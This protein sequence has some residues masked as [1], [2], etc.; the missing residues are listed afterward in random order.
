MNI[1]SD[2]AAPKPHQPR[3]PWKVPIALGA[4]IA[5][6][7]AAYR[8]VYSVPLL[9]DDNEAILNNL[10]I[11][12]LGSAFWPPSRAAVFGRPVLNLSL[13]M[14]YAISGTA[15]WSYHAVNLAIHILAGLTLFGIVRR[16]IVN[17][18]GSS[19]LPIAFSVA[20]IWTLHP[21]QTEAVTYIV[22][23]AESLMALFYLLTLYC[24]IRGAR[25]EGRQQFL[26]FS[27]SAGSCLLG[28]GTKEVM[29][30]APLIVL[31]YDRTFLSGSFREALRRHW[32]PFA[33][34]AA[35]WLALAYL[36]L[37]AY[38]RGVAHDS[39][40]AI[41]W[42]RYALTQLQAVPHYLWL[43]IWPHPLIF[44]YGTSLA[45]V[46]LRILPF[47]LIVICLAAATLW[48]LFKRPSIGF[49]GA[50]FFVILAPTSSIVPVAGETMADYRM[51]LPLIP[52]L[53]LIVLEVFRWLGH[54][55]LPACIAVAAVLGLATECR[56]RDYASEQA[57]W[58][59]VV[60]KL[61]ENW[62]AQGN[63]GNALS[64]VPGRLPDAIVHY[65]A[66]LKINPDFANAHNNL[67]LALANFPD[68][69]PD[70]IAHYEAALKINP[71]YPEAHNNLGAAY[72]NIPGHISDAIAQF[73]AALRI[74][75]DYPDAHN[76]LGAVIANIPGRLPDAI[77]QFRAAL[78]DDPDFAQAHLN[79][80]TALLQTDSQ[81]REARA[82][83]EAALRLRP[84]WKSVIRP[85]LTIQ[86][87]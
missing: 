49:L 76:N 87:Q 81:S 35:T 21:L 60:D 5:G 14:N 48:A 6:A 27:L 86:N 52:V 58:A 11:R 43:C 66:A 13:A 33:A 9:Y 79:L 80:G 39:V 20:L 82:E 65:E 25:A 2:S 41:A 8:N 50:S 36:V 7:L 1:K 15:V 74:N 71:K 42:W 63:L 75:P 45:P 54:A 10:T 55:A 69:L 44:D 61:P 34:M 30:S 4:I 38:G 83:L 78:R 68:R 26:W 57:I 62:R 22:Q 59:D 46:S 17:R 24:F 70:A 85:M 72:A 31:L 29:A 23:R 28:M 53:V 64:K 67:G 77:S 40:A 73:E 3:N 12:R 18:A 51:Y 56:N 19:P 16:T 47:A 37:S 84:D 32:R